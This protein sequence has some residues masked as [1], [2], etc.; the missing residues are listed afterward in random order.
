MLDRLLPAR[1]DAGYRGLSV[2]LWILGLLA[3]MK[4]ALGAGHILNP[5]GGAQTVSHIPLDAYSDGAAQNIVGLFARMGLEQL[6]L[7][8]VFVVVLVRYRALVPL[9][10]AIATLGQAL[11]FA[12]GAYKPLALAAPSGARPIHLALMA[13]CVVGLVLS[14]TGRGYSA[15]R[16][17]AGTG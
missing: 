15:P 6:L 11:T 17:P 16:G 14:L 2:A 3:F 13:L 1:L 5:D 9:T 10:F 8:M 4:L 7:G 12:L